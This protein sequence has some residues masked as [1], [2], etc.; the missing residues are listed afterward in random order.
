[1]G[2]RRK[3]DRRWVRGT[4][5]LDA[6]LRETLVEFARRR[7]WSLSRVVNEAVGEY[8]VKHAHEACGLGLLSREELREAKE[9]C[10]VQIVLAPELA[11]RL[12][13]HCL[14]TRTSMSE[15]IAGALEVHLK[16]T[17]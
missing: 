7:D 5:T 8:L 3:G 1:M 11:D 14:R 17:N 2:Q 4:F 16:R 15:V 6:D 10:R 13:A 12:R 9:K